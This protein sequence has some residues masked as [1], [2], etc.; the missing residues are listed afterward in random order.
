[1]DYP[2]MIIANNANTCVG[3]SS[4]VSFF[5]FFLR[6]V[7]CC[8]CMLAHLH[9]FLNRVTARVQALGAFCAR[10]GG[11]QC[12]FRSSCLREMV[13]RVCTHTHTHI[14]RKMKVRAKNRET[15]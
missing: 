2:E 6:C 10:L 5:F 13:E 7:L 4:K 15:D 14:L 9:A 11:K 12:L 3:S 1:M 8:V